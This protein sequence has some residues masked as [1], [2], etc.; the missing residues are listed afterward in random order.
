MHFPLTRA[1]L[2]SHKKRTS[3]HH[4]TKE[5]NTHLLAIMRHEFR[6]DVIFVNDRIG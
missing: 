5:D 2:R 6:F 1:R 3:M 4:I